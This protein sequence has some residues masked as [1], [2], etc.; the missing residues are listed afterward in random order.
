M[1]LYSKIFQKNIL[2]NSQNSNFVESLNGLQV[3]I[4]S[5]RV[6]FY[7]KN[8]KVIF[9]SELDLQDEDG[10]TRTS[11]GNF[12]DGMQFRFIQ[13]LS[14][15]IANIRRAY[16]CE[17]AFS[18]ASIDRQGFAIHFLMVKS[19]SQEV[20]IE[21][22]GIKDQVYKLIDAASMAFN[23]QMHAQSVQFILKIAELD[24]GW[25]ITATHPKAR[26]ISEIIDFFK[27]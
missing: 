12:E 14:S 25:K 8:E 10:F 20:E 27:K 15:G 21:E 16:E 23:S 6:F 22:N 3:S 7:D 18:I 4:L 24:P 17:G 13:P 11:L 19:P 5:T 9:S 26:I 1:K 2:K